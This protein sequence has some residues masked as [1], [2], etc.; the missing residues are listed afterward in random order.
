MS[1]R[2]QLTTR[3]VSLILGG[4]SIEI[5]GDR[6]SGRTHFLAQIQRE[7]LNREWRTLLVRGVEPLRSA[8][9][10]SL[11]LAGIATAREAR[12]SS[13]AAVV[14]ELIEKLS[15]GPA[16]L[17]VD[18]W[19]EL[20]EI[21]WGAVAA[22]SSATGAPIVLVRPRESLSLRASDGIASHNLGRRL[23]VPL[24]PLRFDEFERA[25]VAHGGQRVD[26]SSLS[27]LFALS[28]GNIGIGMAIFDAAAAEGKIERT[29]AQWVAS[30]DLWC[31]SLGLVVEGMLSTLDASLVEALELVA[32]VGT[33]D[34]DALRPA[35]D[36]RT[37]EQLE[38]R[39]LIA[40]VPSGQRL[41]VTVVPPL[42][43]E[44]FRAS[45][46]MIR[47]MRLLDQV[48][49]IQPTGQTVPSLD[50]AL[51]RRDVHAAQFVRVVHDRLRVRHLVAQKEWA[52]NPQASAAVAYAEA[53]IRMALPDSVVDA[54]LA[55]T[56]NAPVD[57]V[58]A[59]IEWICLKAEHRAF[60]HD[61][62]LSSVQALRA[63][64]AAHGR[65]GGTL[66]AK[67]VQLEHGL[68]GNGDLTTLVDPDDEELPLS[69]R[70][71]THRTL[72][73]VHSSR[74]NLDASTRHLEVAEE[75][76]ATVSLADEIVAGMNHLL[77]GA[78]QDATT[79][80]ARGWDIARA[81]LEPERMRAFGF[82]LSMC[83]MFAGRYSDVDEIIERVKALGDP[84][85]VPPFADRDLSVIASVLASRRGHRRAAERLLDEAER[86]GLP[87]GPFPGSNPSWASAQLIA[88]AGNHEQAVTH[89]VHAADALWDRGA[90]AAAALGYLAALEIDPTPQRL[91][92]LQPRI[93]A[94]A[95]PLVLDQLGYLTALIQRDAEE[96][97]AS[98]ATLETSGRYGL[99]LTAYREAIRLHADQGTRD[100]AA[101]LEQYLKQLELNLK[102]QRIESVRFRPDFVEL[103]DREEQ[104]ARLAA[105]ALS[106]QQIAT[107]LVLSVRTVE[108]H[109]HRAMRKCGAQRRGELAEFFDRHDRKG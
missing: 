104:I 15:P 50:P 73:L 77:S 65:H 22:A 37:F 59:G 46:R 47:R 67:A 30:G 41:L 100:R 26:P 3:T 79:I 103:T 60:H 89:L 53:T 38:A 92:A 25:L 43:V 32:F 13:V 7:L 45:P 24:P 70:V 23:E 34:V 75:L 20:D 39:G 51:G 66:L 93:A 40:T 29:D 58:E 76:D 107:E 68:L 1:T 21:S 69:V 55:E 96:V 105:A 64:A 63:A 42:V 35:L 85:S 10:S 28:A 94:V 31:E 9:L 98:A 16:A 2:E 81:Q 12:A 44:Y 8:P 109:L 91:T 80:A 78:V 88:G 19:H 61:E 87:D 90:L 62:A 54:V 27:Q 84:V 48:K 57:N 56:A 83:G 97:A 106:N 11:A 82:L 102:P 52:L 74:G 17:L 101:Q 14:E 49:Q 86:F 95:I 99:A 4:N 5:T 71:A 6:G 72:A 33:V 36:G 18:D 108:S